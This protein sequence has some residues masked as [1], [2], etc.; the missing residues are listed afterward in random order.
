M[1]AMPT[2]GFQAD[3]RQGSYRTVTEPVP[4]HHATMAMP[5]RG[6]PKGWTA[7]V[8]FLRRKDGMIEPYARLVE[9]MKAHP[10]RSRT[11]QD[12]IARGL[13]LFW[14]F[15]QIR[16]EEI[17]Q[18][19][20]ATGLHHQEA[21][22]RAFA[23]NLVAGSGGVD[24]RDELRWPRTGVGRAKQLV[25]AI[26]HFAEWNDHGEARSGIL[27]EKLSGAPQDHMSVTDMLVWSRMRNVSMLKHIARPKVHQH[28][29]IVDF[30]ND[31]RGF[32][33]DAVKFFPPNRVEQL[34]WE[35]HCRSA[36]YQSNPFLKF[37]VR[38]QMMA[39]L[40]AWGGL[41]RSDGLHLWVN[42]VV[43]ERGKPGHALV[44]L[45][46]PSQAFIEWP[47]RLTGRMVKIR[48]G[49]VL[50][51][52]YGLQPRNEV[53]RGR[54]H[55]GWKSLDLNS[56]HQAFVYWLDEAAGDLF[57]VLY[58]G[59]IRYVRTPLMQ[60]R[61]ALGGADHPFLFVSEGDSNRDG[62][63]VGDPL[64]L[65]AYE[66]SHQRAVERIGLNHSKADGTST[67]GLRHLYG[68]TLADLGVA[69]GVIKK[70]LHH[71]HLLSQVPY[72]V[73]TA[74]RVNRVLRAA[75]SGESLPLEPLTHESSRALR[76][77]HEYIVGGP[78]HE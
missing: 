55:A 78:G 54:Y 9:Y 64:S 43:E 56:D 67:H 58:S 70:G 65:Q 21:L 30:G 69:P 28:R 44:V 51:G 66:R 15:C 77:L 52:Y 45:N 63:M 8:L 36:A 74:D 47:D 22:F 4:L 19:A 41:R 68:Q 40:D 34:I 6:M 39:I 60:R 57:W 33:A 42:D 75:A 27:P 73:P 38:D 14:D 5:V 35:G 7:R 20:K 76:S 16:G 3:R 37:N 23:V 32:G 53:T 29:S 59:Y 24:I 18:E 11:W 71:R 50:S 31:T 13:G 2:I 46:H 48:R 62:G 1:P 10:T 61:I 17:C 72:T 49:E 12:T 26:E 25:S